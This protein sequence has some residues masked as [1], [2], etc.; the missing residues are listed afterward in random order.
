[1]EDDFNEKIEHSSDDEALYKDKGKLT[2]E[3][4]NEMHFGRGQAY[5]D[6]VSKKEKTRRE[7]FKEIIDKSKAYKEAHK[8]LKSVN[9]EL[10]QELDEDYED[11][12]GFLNFSRQK[13][14]A[15]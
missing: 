6:E 8:D 1:M 4:V 7:V 9:M 14:G 13:N 12:C 2:E 5:E 10:I 3:M 15:P 11:I